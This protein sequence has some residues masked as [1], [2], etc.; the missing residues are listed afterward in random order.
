MLS[1][2]SPTVSQWCR[3]MSQHFPHLLFGDDRLQY[4]A[5]RNHVK[6]RHY[7]KYRNMLYATG[8]VSPVAVWR[9]SKQLVN[10]L[11]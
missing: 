9:E 8:E 1:N 7:F 10:V 6:S 11:L 3:S 2:I 4:Y 5:E